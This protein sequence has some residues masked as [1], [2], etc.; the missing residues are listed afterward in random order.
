MR[1]FL[2][3]GQRNWIK[4]E[5]TKYDMIWY[6]KCYSYL[7]NVIM[8]GSPETNTDSLILKEKYLDLSLSVGI[9]RMSSKGHFF[10]EI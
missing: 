8:L 6:S 4:R 10:A 9:F 3:S 1:F 7:R 5:L 2:F